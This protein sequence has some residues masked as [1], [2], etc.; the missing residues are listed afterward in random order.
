MWQR[1][2]SIQ[3]TCDVELNREGPFRGKSV[4]SSSQRQASTDVVVT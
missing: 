4:G 2:K 1:A 3:L